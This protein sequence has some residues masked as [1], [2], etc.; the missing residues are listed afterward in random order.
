MNKEM[1]KKV[2]EINKKARYTVR[3][4]RIKRFVQ[5][6][7]DLEKKM[8]KVQQQRSLGRCEKL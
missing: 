4:K 2:D 8:N 3:S 6:L 5:F 7:S 1:C